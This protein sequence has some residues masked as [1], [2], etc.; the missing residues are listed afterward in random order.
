MRVGVSCCGYCTCESGPK[1]EPPYY[2]V[3]RELT[4]EIA[5]HAKE[6]GVKQ[7][8]FMSNQIVFHESRSLQSEVLTANTLENPNGFY[9][10]SK[11]VG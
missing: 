6:H 7:F 3:N 10:D 5:R 2:K 1:M 4:L 8:I 11:W 9:G